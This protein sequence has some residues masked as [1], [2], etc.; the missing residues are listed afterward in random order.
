M[1][2]HHHL[3]ADVSD[4]ANLYRSD[5]LSVFV[6]SQTTLLTAVKLTNKFLR[7]CK[8]RWDRSEDCLGLF[9]MEDPVLSSFILILDHPSTLTAGMYSSR[10][11]NCMI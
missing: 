10:D 2:K 11:L 7:C 1:I 5:K 3:S 4:D 8:W 6:S 9:E